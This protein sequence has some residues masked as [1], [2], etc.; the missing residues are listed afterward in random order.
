[1]SEGNGYV[2]R[3]AFFGGF[4]RKYKDVV[5]PNFG[6]PF[7]GHTFQICN[8]SEGD[9]Q[10]RE[11]WSKNKRGEYIPERLLQYRLKVIVDGTCDGSGNRMFSDAD[12]PVLAEK[13]VDGAFTRWLS[14]Q[15]VEFCRFKDEGLEEATKN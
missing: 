7:D 5:C 1:M 12:I 3:D 8:V 6:L 15:I 2:S 13:D 11:K 9:L 10:K 14:D 4:Q